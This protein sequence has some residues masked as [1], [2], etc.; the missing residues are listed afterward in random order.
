M[1]GKL[2]RD[3]LRQNGAPNVLAFGAERRGEAEGGLQ[4]SEDGNRRRGWKTRVWP[5]KHLAFSHTGQGGAG[6]RLG[7]LRKGWKAYNNLAQGAMTGRRKGFKGK[8]D[9]PQ[10]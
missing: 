2:Q 9:A 1:R 10:L 8:T 5:G 6:A 4:G 7:R 3:R